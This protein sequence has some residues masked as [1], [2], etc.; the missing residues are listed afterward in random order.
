MM[1]FI[2]APAIVGIGVLGIYKLF[3]LYARRRE[4]LTII[5]KTDF[6]TKEPCRLAALEGGSGWGQFFSLRLGS[7]L[8]GIGV[9]LL[10]GFM[11]ASVTSPAGFNELYAAQRGSQAKELFSGIY[12]ASVLLCGGLGLIVAFVLERRIQRKDRD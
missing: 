7:L 12:G 4:R 3:E 9:G 11:L 10:L 8:V 1:D 2:T 5:E 6:M